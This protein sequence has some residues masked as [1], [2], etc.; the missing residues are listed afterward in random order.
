MDTD[1]AKGGSDSFDKDQSI[2]LYNRGRD[3]EGG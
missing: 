3:I 2:C 1:R